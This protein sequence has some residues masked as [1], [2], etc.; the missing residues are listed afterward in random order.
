MKVT[1]HTGSSESVIS[2]FIDIEKVFSDLQE[3]L[4]I[5]NAKYSFVLSKFKE[6]NELPDDEGNLPLF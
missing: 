5:E 2:S 3:T 6:W 1:S 4:E